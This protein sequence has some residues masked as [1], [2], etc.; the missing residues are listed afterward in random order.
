MSI[1]ELTR[2]WSDPIQLRFQN[3]DKYSCY[4]LWGSLQSPLDLLQ[5]SDIMPNMNRKYVIPP[6]VADF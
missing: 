6:E 5:K 1:A 4:K 3:M 2:T